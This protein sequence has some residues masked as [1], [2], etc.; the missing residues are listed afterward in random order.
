VKNFKLERTDDRYQIGNPDGNCQN[1]LTMTA[2]MCRN[3]L[4]DVDSDMITVRDAYSELPMVIYRF[5]IKNRR[6]LEENRG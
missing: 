1:R 3:G 2:I 6:I 4:Y 5:R